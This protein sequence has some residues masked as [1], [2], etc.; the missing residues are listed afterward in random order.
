MQGNDIAQILGDMEKIVISRGT[1]A[2]DRKAADEGR[3]EDA[4]N[5]FKA[6]SQKDTQFYEFAKNCTLIRNFGCFKFN[7]REKF[8]IVFSD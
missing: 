4:I 2:E 6:V 5:C 3:Y 7:S 8:I 1:F